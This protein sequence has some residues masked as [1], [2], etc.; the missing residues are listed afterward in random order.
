MN[1]TGLFI[2]L[3][4]AVIVGV[5]FS[6]HAQFDLDLSGLFFDPDTHRFRIY[7]QPW[8]QHARDA[9]RWLIILLVAPGFLALGGK[10][11]W[12]RRRMLIGGRSALFLVLTLALGPGLLANTL[13]KDHW[14]RSRPIDVIEFGG[15]DPF[16]PWWNPGGPCPNN[17]SFIAGEPSGAFWTLAPAAMAPPQWR[18]LAYGGAIAFGIA[19]GVL[20]IA[21]GG[22]FFTDVAFAGIFMYLVVWSIH[23][24]IFRW[25]ATRLDENTV[26]HAIGRAGEAIRDVLAAVALWIGRLTGKRF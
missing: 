14:G 25:R 20:R 13:L 5:L 16:T 9:S 2:A 1:R 8:E 4:V 17:C 6:I 15:A 21:A 12:P 3:A 22:H 19:L 24:F 26:D 18:L 10:L 23:G 7:A 11:I